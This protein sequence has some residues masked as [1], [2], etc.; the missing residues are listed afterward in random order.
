MKK[1]KQ[2]KKQVNQLQQLI[3]FYLIEQELCVLV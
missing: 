1:V 3:D 2:L